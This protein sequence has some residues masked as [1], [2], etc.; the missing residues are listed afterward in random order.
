M[1]VFEEYKEGANFVERVNREILCAMCESHGL[2]T[3]G[4]KIDLFLRLKKWVCC[5]QFK[6]F[7]RSVPC[8]YLA[9]EQHSPPSAKGRNITPWCGV[10]A[11]RYGRS[12][13]RYEIDG[14]SLVDES[15]TFELG[16]NC[17]GKTDRR[18]MDGRLHGPPTRYTHQTLGKPYGSTLRAPLQFHGSDIRS[19]AR[20]PTV[21]HGA[22]D[23]RP[24]TFDRALL[25]WYETAIQGE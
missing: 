5:S 21:H 7:I 23:R 2:D 16:D 10:R 1:K 20:D 13:E 9:R 14:A 17:E 3:S 25:E 18:P 4:Y 15:C 8:F 24:R 11:R 22:D 6:P 12:L 19:T